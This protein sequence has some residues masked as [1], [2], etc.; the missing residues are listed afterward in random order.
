VW[1]AEITLDRVRVPVANRLAHASGFGATAKVLAAT[2]AGVAWEAAGHA[3]AAYEAALA[4][5]QERVQFGSPLAGFQLVQARLAKM[6]AEVTSMQLVCFRLAQLAAAGRMTD[7]MASLAKM[8]NAAKARQV[9][10]DARDLL[11]GN[12]ILL[13]NHVAR[14]QSDMEAVHTYE[15][16]D[17][18]QSLILGREITGLSAFSAA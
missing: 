4:Y 5:A 3:M 15:G 1:Q 9:V 13:E 11:G 10:A 18:I 14:H 16:T 12:G 17:A 6:L 7:G 8:N 2:R